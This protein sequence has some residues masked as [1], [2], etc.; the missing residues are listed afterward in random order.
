MK[1]T[2]ARSAMLECELAELSPSGAAP[3]SRH[4]AECRPC[5]ARAQAIERGTQSLRVAAAAR[6]PIHHPLARPGTRRLLLAGALAVAAGLLA[7]VA[8]RVEPGATMPAAPSRPAV[9]ALP[10]SAP[11]AGLIT[12]DAAQGRAVSIVRG[13]ETVDVVFHQTVTN[14]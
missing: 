6:Q 8:L 7:I 3:L 9:V 4:L 12:I 5:L 14:D 13:D 10:R 11:N 2:D 1:C